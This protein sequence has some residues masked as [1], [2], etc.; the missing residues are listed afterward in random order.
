MLIIKKTESIE[1]MKVF[2]IYEKNVNIKKDKNKKSGTIFK[3]FIN[4]HCV[5]KG[6]RVT[7]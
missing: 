3:K 2:F 7:S 6:E 5:M 1:M 4:F